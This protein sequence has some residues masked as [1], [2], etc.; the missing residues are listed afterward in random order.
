MC[1]FYGVQPPDPV[2]MKALEEKTEQL[3]G[4]IPERFPGST[5]TLYVL[6][7]L[8]V[9]IAK[10]G[11]CCCLCGCCKSDGCCCC[12]CRLCSRR[13]H[14]ESP[15]Q[16]HPEGGE[17]DGDYRDEEKNETNAAIREKEIETDEGSASKTKKK[18]KKKAKIN[19]NI[20]Y[21]PPHIIY[22]AVNHSNPPDKNIPAPK[23][24]DLESDVLPF[25][26]P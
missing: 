2:L 14:H 26:Y 11:K 6:R 7:K 22:A 25:T 13:K 8:G 9:C 19:P 24:T 21:Y 3:Q 12:C 5:I 10:F 1:K 4:R 15:Y 18:K 16:I 23:R 17:G 20:L